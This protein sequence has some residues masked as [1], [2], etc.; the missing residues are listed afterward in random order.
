MAFYLVIISTTKI[1]CHGE[2]HYGEGMV[3]PKDRWVNSYLR[4]WQAA[5][6]AILTSSLLLAFNVGSSPAA[7]SHA[8]LTTVHLTSL[9]METSSVGWATDRH[10]ASPTALFGGQIL[11]TVDGGRQWVNVTPPQVTFN[12]QAGPPQSS[13]QYG[14]RFPQRINSLDRDRNRHFDEWNWNAAAECHA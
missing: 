3:L 11:H 1:V 9:Q 14:C 5:L 2:S 7:S 6:R 4:R 10:L 12:D 13:A 8:D